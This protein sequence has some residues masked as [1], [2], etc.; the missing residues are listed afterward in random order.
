MYVAQADLAGDL[1]D[2][3]EEDDLGGVANNN[4]SDT[5]QGHQMDVSVAT[6]SPA[7]FRSSS[8]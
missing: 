1:V 6:M 3:K 2:G 7:L 4:A 5:T 8:D